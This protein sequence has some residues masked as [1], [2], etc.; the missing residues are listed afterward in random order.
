MDKDE[1]ELAFLTLLVAVLVFAV[2]AF[3]MIGCSFVTITTHQSARLVKAQDGEVSLSRGHDVDTHLEKDN[4][5]FKIP[6]LK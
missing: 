6:L 4:I 1:E 2:I 5:K 3:S